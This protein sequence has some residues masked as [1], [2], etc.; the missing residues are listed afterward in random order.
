MDDR[1][2]GHFAG[3]DKR[4]RAQKRFP[5]GLIRVIA[6]SGH[7]RSESAT[8]GNSHTDTTLIYADR[9]ERVAL[10]VAEKAG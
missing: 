10:E 2:Y 1:L 4:S 6:D 8:L 5:F 3:R 7:R 9:P